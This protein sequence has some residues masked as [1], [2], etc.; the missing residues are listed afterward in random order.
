MLAV[1]AIGQLGGCSTIKSVSPF[2]S[3]VPYAQ[4]IQP[5][6]ARPSSPEVPVYRKGTAPP[7][8]AAAPAPA[9]VAQTPAPSPSPETPPAPAAPAPVA[10]TPPPNPSAEARPAPATPPPAA[11]APTS[12]SS[13]TSEEGTAAKPAPQAV[14]SDADLPTIPAERR[15]FQDDG[16]YSNLAQVPERPKNLPTFAEARAEEKSLAANRAGAAAP[17]QAGSAAPSAEIAPKPAAAT[18]VISRPED[19]APCE[20]AARDA[21]RPA[22]TVRF[23]QGSAALTSDQ[24]ATLADALP[25][26]RGAQGIIRIVGHGDTEPGSGQ[27]ATRFDLAIARAGAVAEALAGFGIPAQRIAVAVACTDAAAAGASVQL[28]INL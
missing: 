2:T 26:V 16:R 13:I 24:R 5:T 3:G 11:A 6:V 28:Y 4:D 19:R 20:A 17:D 7:A 18:P 15:V 1:L 10:Q 12:H 23:D 25:D 9:P 8:A 14:A 21:A 22:A 27:N